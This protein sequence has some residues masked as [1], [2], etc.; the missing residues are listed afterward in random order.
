[1][2][3]MT[4]IL[5]SIASTQLTGATPAPNEWATITAEDFDQNGDFAV[6]Y[7]DDRVMLMP[8]SKAG[9]EWAYAHLPSDCPRWAGGGFIF[10]AR[11]AELVIKAATR[12]KLRKS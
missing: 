7:M 3:D 9:R 12:D 4:D 11:W 8:L 5:H 6:E 2:S 1:M 10:E